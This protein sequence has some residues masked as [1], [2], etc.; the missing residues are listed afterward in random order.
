MPTES[1]KRVGQNKREECRQEPKAQRAGASSEKGIIG[2]C[3]NKEV[4][5]IGFSWEG[6]L[7][8]QRK[9]HFK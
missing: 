9:E 6:S 7:M 2:D 1:V 8:T 4:K 3:Y 5:I